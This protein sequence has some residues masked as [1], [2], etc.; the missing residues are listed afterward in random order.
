MS[1]FPGPNS[2]GGWL[3]GLLVAVGL[4]AVLWAIS[5]WLIGTVAVV[6]T[7]HLFVD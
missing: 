3:A 7:W 5:P 6:F 2:G 4:G 1:Q